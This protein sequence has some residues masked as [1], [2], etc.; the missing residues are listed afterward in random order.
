VLALALWLAMLAPQWVLLLLG[1]KHLARF[2]EAVARRSGLKLL[3]VCS[4]MGAVGLAIIGT[5]IVCRDLLGPERL[6]VQRFVKNAT[7]AQEG[8]L[9]IVGILLASRRRAGRDAPAPNVRKQPSRR[10][11]S[12]L[13]VGLVVTAVVLVGLALGPFAG[14]PAQAQIWRA[15]AFAVAGLGMTIVLLLRAGKRSALTPAIRRETGEMRGGDRDAATVG[16]D[17]DGRARH[18]VRPENTVRPANTPGGK[19]RAHARGRAEYG[20]DFPLQVHLGVL[21]ADGRT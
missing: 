20:D 10:Y 15:L 6:E 21:C 2:R 19:R 17:S 14:R 18:T 8:L 12:R 13:L 5:A 16:D 3:A 4:W 7:L 1:V 11:L 9:V